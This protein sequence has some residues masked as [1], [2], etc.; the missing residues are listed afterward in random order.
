MYKHRGIIS[1]F[2]CVLL[3][4]LP[5]ASFG[6]GGYTGIPL[7]FAACFLRIWARM[8]IGEHSRAGEL[9][10]PEIVKTGPY[11][12][13][14]HPLYLSNFMAG[15][16]FAVFH[17]GFSFGALG[18]CGV[19]GGFLWWL[20]LNENRFLSRISNTTQKEQS[21]RL[22]PVLWNDRFTWLWQIVIILLI[23]LR[24]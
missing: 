16:A 4:L 6:F 14:R 3:L 1:A 12:Y 19:Y 5:P 2:L 15:I 10:C 18:F 24:K 20:A 9:A 8:H 22:A 17:A 11:R 23:F 13:I 21:R 7:F